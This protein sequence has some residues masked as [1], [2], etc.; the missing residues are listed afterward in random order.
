LQQR[1]M[2]ARSHSTLKFIAISLPIG[3]GLI[4]I[5]CFY[6]AMAGVATKPGFP[7]PEAIYPAMI[8]QV[9]PQWLLLIAILAIIAATG[10]TAYSMV[11]TLSSIVAK[12]YVRPVVAGRGRSE[13]H[14]SE[15]QS[16]FDLV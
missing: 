1:W 8:M 14:T 10:S 13:E 6:I 16:R 15:L 2:A 3:T 7:T 11:L 4:Y 5:C 12:E 9:L